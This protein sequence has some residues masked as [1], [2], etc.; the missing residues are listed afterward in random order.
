[1]NPVPRVG[2]IPRSAY[3]HC[4]RP[5]ILQRHAARSRI[6]P[7]KSLSKARTHP[8]QSPDFQRRL[9][10]SIAGKSNMHPPPALKDPQ[11]RH[12]QDRTFQQDHQ[13]PG[14]SLLIR[15]LRPLL[16][17]TLI[18]ST[19]LLAGI[20][21][22]IQLL[23]NR[24]ALLALA[25]QHPS[26][27]ETLSPSLYHPPDPATAA[28]NTRILT[29]PL[30]ESLRRN[31]AFLESRPHLKIPEAL[32]PTNLTGG[33]LMG[34]GKIAVPPLVF[35]E[36]QGKS[37][38]SIFYLGEQLCGHPGMVHGGCLATL[39]DE[40]LARCC[41]PALPSRLGFTANLKVEY[42]RP[43][44]AGMCFV[45]RAETVK[46]EGR[47]AWVRGWIEE[48]D[49]GREGLTGERLVEAE[50]LF[51]EPRYAAKVRSIYSPD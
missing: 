26:D 42:R 1:M 32:R 12:P 15:L 31:P 10:S 6:L 20:Y 37:M 3:S 7:I 30:A 11:L 24:A 16:K 51:I 46:V 44:R 48:L 19:C 27:A 22:G 21:L 13:P 28:I 43:V 41:F 8:L 39:L 2:L 14:R 17:Y 36:G 25:G 29:C 23:P 38:Y 40:G 47:K 50:A 35:G 9:L 18:G 5:S 34:P 49:E 45:L 33:T 4:R